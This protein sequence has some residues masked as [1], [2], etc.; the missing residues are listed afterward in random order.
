MALFRRVLVSDYFVLGLCVLY[1]AAVAPFTPG[2]L[3]V[4]NLR[5]ILASF[6]PL[7]VVSLGQTVVLIA[8]GIDLSV[9]SVIGLASVVGA[10]AMNH[11]TGW[12]ANSSLA[13]PAGIAPSSLPPSR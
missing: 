1:V 11:E 9:T 6:L 13:A 7:L 10:M 8:R 12:L 3:T 5:N 4:E 2:F